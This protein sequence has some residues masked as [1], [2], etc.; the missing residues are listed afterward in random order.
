MIQREDGRWVV[1]C[2]QI[3]DTPRFPWRGMHQDV[4]RH[5]FTVRELKD[6]I[7]VLALYKFNIFHLHLTDDQ[8]WRLEIKSYPLLT[9]KGAWRTENNH[10]AICKERAETD[11]T[12]IIPEKH[13]RQMDGQRVYGGFYTQEQMRDIV[14]YAAARQITIIPEID[15]PGHFKAAIDQYPY[16][17][18]RGEGGW[19]SKF[20]DPLCP[21]NEQVFEFVEK[22]IREV[23]MLFPAEY[24]HIGGDEVEKTQWKQCSKCQARVKSEG[25]KNE[26]ELQSYFI[27]RVE[28]IINDCDKKMIGWD[29]IHQGG[30]SPTATVMQWRSWAMDVAVHAAKGGNDVIMCPTS[31]CYFDYT[32]ETTGTKHVYHFEPVPEGL[33]DAQ[34]K[35][36]LGTQANLW[37]EWIPNAKR[38]DYMAM[39]RMLALA[40]VAWSPKDQRNWDSFRKRLEQQYP[41]L[42]RMGV[43]YRVPDLEGLESGS[44]FLDSV[45]V[46]IRKP[47]KDMKV[48]YTLDGSEP[49]TGSLLYTKPITVR[50]TTTIKAKAYLPGGRSTATRIGTYDKQQLA[51]PIDVSD[52]KPGM[53]CEYYLGG[54]RSVEKISTLP[55]KKTSTEKQIEIPSYAD[56]P[57]FGLVYK[58]YIRVPV[59]GVYTFYTHSDDGSQLLI[60]DRL[61]VQNDGPHAPREMSGQVALKAGVHPIKVLFFEAGGGETLSVSYKVPG[62]AKKPISEDQLSH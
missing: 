27:K 36:I 56:A 18:C 11:P 5:F 52:T 39:P 8:G 9:E 15:I 34:T 54:V 49:D 45:T 60:G 47:R 35:H 21:G 30:L 22:I 24:I 3:T 25:L 4:S 32:Y 23:A 53:T 37:S 62:Q 58:G 7:D 19:G 2:A 31:H 13:Y 46:D 33:N 14:A 40:E 44:V 38:R 50:E 55:L 42:D 12:F 1:P 6:F 48:Y 41:R 43:H 26:F 51:E 57:A 10:D 17:S 20:S 29:E 59:D 28:K 16:L 61:V